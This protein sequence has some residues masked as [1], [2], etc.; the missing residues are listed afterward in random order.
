MSRFIGL[1][2]GTSMDAID[3]ALVEIAATD[4]EVIDY[5]QYPLRAS[6]Q[7]E[8]K[9]IS[10]DSSLEDLTRLD[11]QTGE[12]FAEAAI[13]ILRGN[14]MG[15]EDVCAIGSHGQTALHL[16]RAKAPRSL[17]I[18]DPNVIAL[19]VGIPVVA[20]FR[21]ADLAAG[22]EG[23]PLAAALHAWKFRSKQ[24]DR[25]VLNI[26]G[27]ANITTLPADAQRAVEGFDTGPGNTL[28]DGWTQ[29]CLGQD[30]DKDGEWAA[31]GTPDD[32][33]L[34][35]MLQDPY[36]SMPPPKSTGRDD[37]NLTWLT[38]A[39]EQVGR[40]LSEQDVQAS[41]LELTVTSIARAITQRLPGVREALV[42]GGGAHNKTL[43]QRLEATLS[44]IKVQSSDNH[45]IDPDAVEAVTFAWLAEQRL[46]NI[47]ANLPSVTGARLPVVMGGVYQPA[48]P[49]MTSG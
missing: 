25:V 33:L 9:Q 3:T 4:L 21:R 46:R 11:V 14:N 40:P 26:G 15:A 28:M 12:A 49:G 5:R 22:G 17:Q 30:F 23:A 2:S 1:M 32:R 20:D 42:C 36:F 39:M 34:E 18:G 44:G 6:L 45:G 37:F 13:A 48:A 24:V 38:A 41:L 16:P 43:R 19:R 31:G 27:I 10:R 7:T 29:R 47:P 8:L 35:L